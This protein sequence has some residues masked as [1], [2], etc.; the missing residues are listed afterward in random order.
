MNVALVHRRLT[1]QGG[2]ERFLVG[3]ARFLHS[4][5]HEVHVYC[6]WARPDLREELPVRLHPLPRWPVGGLV[7]LLGLWWASGRAA[8]GGHDAVMGFGRTRGHTLWRCGGGAH[9]AYLEACRPGWWLDPVAWVERALDRRAALSAARVVSPSARAAQDLVRC[10]GLDPARVEVVHNG[11]DSARFSPDPARRAWAREQLGLGPGPALAFLGTGFARKGLDVAAGVARALGLPLFALGTDA[12]L[13]RWRRRYPEVRF[14]GAVDA[15]ERWLPAA[16]ALLLPTR[17]EPY[18]N[19]V[20][21]AMA[22]GVPPV[23]TRCNGAAEVLP[24]PRLVGD[25]LEELRCATEWALGEGEVLRSVVRR[26]AEAL[27]REAAF[28]RVEALLLHPRAA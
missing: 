19:A 2:T 7:R 22:C 8:R 4:R 10:Y 20:L 6:E 18:G 17:Y 23:T 27:P 14:V 11:V 9:A 13:G 5:G 26:A 12:H 16:D 3:L 25:T 28:A 24:D 15:P 21:E 1:E